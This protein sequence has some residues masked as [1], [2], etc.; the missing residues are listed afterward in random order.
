[1]ERRKCDLGLNDPETSRAESLLE[2]GSLEE[3][4]N[5]YHSTN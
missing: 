3:A 4:M 5:W 1:M 2:V